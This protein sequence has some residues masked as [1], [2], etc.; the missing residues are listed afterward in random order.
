[1]NKAKHP[2][3]CLSESRWIIAPW[4]WGLG[5]YTLLGILIMTS[6]CS[7]EQTFHQ[8]ERKI[9]REWKKNALPEWPELATTEQLNQCEQWL[10]PLIEKLT[11]D[12]DPEQLPPVTQRT[13][14]RQLQQLRDLQDR[15]ADLRANPATFNLPGR[16]KARLSQDTPLIDRLRSLKQPLREAKHYYA[17]ARQVLQKPNADALAFAV[18]K[19]EQG[20]GFFEGELADSIRVSSLSPLEKKTLIQ[21]AAQAKL[22]AKDYLGWCE[23]QVFSQQDPFPNSPSPTRD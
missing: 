10:T 7:A 4:S 6:G 8:F 13:Y 19:H 20:I 14:V 1:M 12:I 15:C 21:L 16:L 22:A 2:P 18:Q 5:Y 23:S 3:A 11:Q 17:N 9:K